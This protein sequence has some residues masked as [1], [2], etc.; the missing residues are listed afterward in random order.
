MSKISKPE[1][2]KQ[3]RE[4]AAYYEGRIRDLGTPIQHAFQSLPMLFSI[5]ALLA[6]GRVFSADG[7]LA[8][9]FAATAIGVGMVLVVQSGN[10]KRAL[11]VEAEYAAEHQLLF[12][13]PPRIELI[14]FALPASP[15]RRRQ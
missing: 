11:R 8:V 3:Q 4:L 6:S 14:G 15:S 1:I 5:V 12:G 9:L 10:G 13:E 2:L 7:V